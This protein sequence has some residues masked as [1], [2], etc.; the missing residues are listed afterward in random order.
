MKRFLFI[1]VFAAVSLGASAQTMLVNSYKPTGSGNY[2]SSTSTVTMIGDLSYKT[3]FVIS[4]DGWVKFNIG[5]GWE[6]LS[7]VLGHYK[8]WN[9]WGDTLIDEDPS[10]VTVLADGVKICDEVVRLTDVPRFFSLNIKGV[11]ELAFRMVQGPRHAAFGDVAL[12]KAGQTPKQLSNVLTGPAKTIELVKDLK[13]YSMGGKGMRGLRLIGEEKMPTAKINGIVYNYGIATS[14]DMAL[15]GESIAGAHFYLRKQYRK[16]SFIVGPID[17]TAHGHGWITVK[18]DGKIIYEEEMKHDDTAKQVVLDIGNC[19]KLTLES[20]YIDGKLLTGLVKIMVYPEGAEVAEAGR[21]LQTGE[22]PP[23]PR[24]K[25]LPDVTKLVSQVKPYAI[26]SDLKKQIYDGSSDYITFSMGGVRFSEG[27]ILHET[28]NFWDENISSYAVFDLGNEFD[29]LRFTVGYVSKSWAMENDYLR[30]WA[31]DEVIFQ[32][33]LVATSPNLEITL[34]INKCRRLKFENAGQGSIEGIAA[35]GIADAVVYRGDNTSVTPFSHPKPEFPHEIDLIDLE[36]P[37]IHYVSSY[38][39]DKE[40]IFHDGTTKKEYFE[41]NGQRIYKG[42]ILKTSSHF[43]FDAGVFA[44]KDNAAAGIAGSIAVGSAFVPIAAAGSAV[45]GST[46]AGVAALMAIAAGGTKVEN[47]CAAFNT[48]GE[49]NSL[50]FTVACMRTAHGAPASNYNETL[51]IGVNGEPVQELTVYE[52][53]QP[54][55]VTIP[56]GDCHQLMFWLSNTDGTSG[57]YLFYDLKLTKDKLALNVPAT[58]RQTKAE[59][60]NMVWDTPEKLPFEWKK[61]K[62]S[63]EKYVDSYLTDVTIMYNQLN[64]LMERSFIDY[65]IHTFYLVT[66]AGQVCKAVRMMP[67]GGG[68]DALLNPARRIPFYYQDACARYEDIRKLQQ[69][70]IDLNIAKANASLG[71]VN[72]GLGA[73]EYSKVVKAAGQVVKRCS[74]VLKVMAVQ[75]A[76]ELEYLTKV[77]DNAIDID[78]KKST[79]KT[80]FCPLFAGDKAPDASELMLVDIFYTD[81]DK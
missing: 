32:Q 42:F 8:N 17:N 76:A 73:I 66:N 52:S 81:E 11:N 1:I 57:T 62:S 78:S 22:A 69:D 59:V 55:T 39:N 6:S 16:L 54:Q 29:Y 30:V 27:F 28:A 26:G 68:E 63:G 5:G 80:I 75:K 43:S 24:L 45:I 46:L 40:A 23:D 25:T 15:I 61:P 14:V 56:I 64:K 48:Y 34:P 3:G 7:F 53:M 20:Q 50:T 38:E 79:E 51:L 47:S 77:L 70:I 2:K 9:P 35:F 33:R 36:K 65:E 74:E 72:L 13:P 58:A 21:A 31:D 18:A 10:V 41:L 67:V 12:W 44:G 49:Y 19:D 71:L 37:Y 60:S 4:E